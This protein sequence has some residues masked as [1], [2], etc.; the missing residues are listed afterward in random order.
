MEIGSVKRMLERTNRQIKSLQDR[1]IMLEKIIEERNKK[2][3]LTDK[4][5]RIWKKAKK[6]LK[7]NESED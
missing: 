5:Y 2:Q 3:L 1:K 4:Q 6:L 7:E